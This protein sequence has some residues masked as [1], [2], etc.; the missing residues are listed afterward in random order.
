MDQLK[1]VLAGLK[2]YYF[3]VC[4]GIILLVALGGWYMATTG[5]D[6]I[7]DAKEQEI[8]TGLSSARTIA[9]TQN[10]PNAQYETGMAK[11]LTKYREDIE[12]AWK[13]KW[14]AQRKLLKWPDELNVG[15]KNFVDEINGILLDPTT[16]GR[17]PIEALNDEEMKE[18]RV[19]SRELYRD[20]IKEELPKL[21]EIIGAHWQPTGGQGGGSYGL[22]GGGDSFGGIGGDAFS[23]MENFGVGTGG[24]AEY[25]NSGGLGG[26]NPNDPPKKPALVQWN[27]ANQGMIQAKSFDWSTPG[28][29][30][31]TTKEV[32]YAQENLWVLENLM[33][34]I[35]K[36]NGE[37]SS[38]HQATIKQIIS[39]EFG[40]DV[41]PIRSRVTVPKL[42]TGMG[43][44]GEYAAGGEGGYMDESMMMEGGE[45]GMMMEGGEGGMMGEGGMAAPIPGEFRYVDKDYKKLTLE[46]VQAASTAPTSENY[47]LTVAKRLPV[48]MKFKMDQREIDKLLVECGNADL[49]VEVR[50]VRVNAMDTNTGGGS[51]GGMGGGGEYGG[52]ESGGMENEFGGGMGGGMMMGGESGGNA[53][54]TEQT[55]KIFDVPVEIYGIIYIYNPVNKALL[56]PEG[57]QEPVEEEPAAESASLMPPADRR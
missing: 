23:G 30:L 8:E 49:M 42:A 20:Y 45:D 18:L 10:H 1:P 43:E 52:M 35:A 33:R 37:I 36:T 48:R 29:N 34:I 55:E 39:I 57:S 26:V 5:I 9:S 27:P 51:Y 25:G 32:L 15:G 41:M 40:R 4:S 31:P 24:G 28:K 53:R 16:G 44:G 22:G 2:K 7:T 6:K 3:W 14:D 21:A 13:E 56:W 17:R 12:Q 54:N 19:P 50:Q 46:E 38:H 47:Y 11:W